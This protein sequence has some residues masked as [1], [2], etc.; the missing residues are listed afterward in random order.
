MI[1]LINLI[2]WKV[3][4]INGGSEL[5]L[6]RCMHLA[7][8]VPIDSRKIWMLL[9]LCSTKRPANVTDP[10]WCIAKETKNKVSR[11]LLVEHI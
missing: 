4:G 2:S 11:I 3:L 10:V 8:L 6:E 1:G 5:R 7:N 9:D